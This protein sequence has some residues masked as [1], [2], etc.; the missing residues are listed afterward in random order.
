MEAVMLKRSSPCP[1]RRNP[2]KHFTNLYNSSDSNLLITPHSS[3]FSGSYS[4]LHRRDFVF[5]P[6]HPIPTNYHGK[7]NRVIKDDRITTKRIKTS[8][9]K[10]EGVPSTATKCLVITSTDWLGPDPS[11]L[12]KEIPG[13]FKLAPSSTCIG[14]G[15]EKFSG[16]VCSH[17]PEPGSLPLP[18]FSMAQK[19]SCNAEV[20]GIDIGA[21]NRLRCLLGI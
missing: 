11:E 5:N 6:S 19:I 10:V 13:V 18:K 2:R 21:T 9:R 14:D 7:P 4:D 12:P 1:K 20:G 16:S 8:G 3:H 17:S 15:L